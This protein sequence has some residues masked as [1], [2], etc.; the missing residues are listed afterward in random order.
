MK[1]FPPLHFTTIMLLASCSIVYVYSKYWSY[2]MH[3]SL[4]TVVLQTRLHLL[5]CI[6]C[7]MCG[8]PG[9]GGED[10]RN[11]LSAHIHWRQSLDQTADSIYHGDEY[12]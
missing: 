5:T 2:V 9:A 11:P 6:V 7:A 12:Y 1:N 4:K 3:Y 8:W 10:G